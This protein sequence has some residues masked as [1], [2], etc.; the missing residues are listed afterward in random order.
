MSRMRFTVRRMMIAVASVA[1]I[2]GALRAGYPACGILIVSTCIGWLTHKLSSETLT[3]MRAR[4]MPVG[5]RRKLDVILGSTGRAA[6]IV[7]ASDFAFL[8]VFF[9]YQSLVSFGRHHLYP[10]R[11][12][13]HMAMG[14]ALGTL[15][16]ISV[17][18]RMRQNKLISNKRIITFFVIIAGVSMVVISML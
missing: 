1:L 2:L 7:L 5:L 13:E 15:A 3:R 18:S 6:A 8:V 4:G 17:A 16:A 10:E 9:S 11:E 14:T 12:P